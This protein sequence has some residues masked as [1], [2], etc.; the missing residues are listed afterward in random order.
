MTTLVDDNQIRPDL[1]KVGDVI[2][3]SVTSSTFTIVDDGNGN[4]TITAPKLTGVIND[5]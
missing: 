5:N 4:L 3:I 1:A 2:T